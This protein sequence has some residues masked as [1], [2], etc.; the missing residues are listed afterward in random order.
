MVRTPSTR[1]VDGPRAEEPEARILRHFAPARRIGYTVAFLARKS[2]NIM[3]TVI[4]VTG[5]MLI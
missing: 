1:T 3:G 5:G 4:D 2:F